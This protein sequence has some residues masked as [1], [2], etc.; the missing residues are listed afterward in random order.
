M[1]PIPDFTQDELEIVR[2]LTERRYRKPITVE[3]A[4]A[5]VQI[6]P[7]SGELTL[8]PTLFWRERDANFV[9][10]KTGE[11]RYRCE[12]FYHPSEHYGT[13]VAAYTDLV[14][15]TTT[16]LRLQADHEAQRTGESPPPRRSE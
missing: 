10:V 16:L 14:E 15:C 4:D 3:L 1:G 6:E 11:R 9:V 7:S 12:F 8:C 2:E 5:E 13:G